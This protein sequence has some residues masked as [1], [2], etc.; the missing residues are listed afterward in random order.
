MIATLLF[1][2]GHLPMARR[3][4]ELT[5]WLVVRVLVINDIAGMMYG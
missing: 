2:A 4:N 5:P 3:L 1:A